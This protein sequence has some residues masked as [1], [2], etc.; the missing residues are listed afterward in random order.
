MI[1]RAY[2]S[3]HVGRQQREREV[4]AMPM[5][6]V[7]TRKRAWT[8]TLLASIGWAGAAADRNTTMLIV[9]LG[10]TLIAAIYFRM[11]RRTK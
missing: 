2:M 3:A 6:V 11:S 9:A 1:D 5:C 8:A 4:Q 10:M 7:K